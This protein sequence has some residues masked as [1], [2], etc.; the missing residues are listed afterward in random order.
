[1]V[2]V[3]M[4]VAVRD[5]V[6]EAYGLMQMLRL[7]CT[8]LRIY[9]ANTVPHTIIKWWVIEHCREHVSRKR[10][11]CRSTNAEGIITK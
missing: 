10:K 2:V 8:L 5:G 3:V 6:T 7:S 4:V 11:V 9:L 1:V